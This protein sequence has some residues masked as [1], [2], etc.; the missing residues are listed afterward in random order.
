MP[1]LYW[2]DLR[3]LLTL[4]SR[5]ASSQ[6]KWSYL[7][8]LFFWSPL[9]W[10]FRLGPVFGRGSYVQHVCTFFFRFSW[11]KL[12][13]FVD[14]VLISLRSGKYGVWV[15]LYI[16]I[17]S[18]HSED[19]RSQWR[20]RHNLICGWK[21]EISPP[22]LVWKRYFWLYVLDYHWNCM[23][24]PVYTSDSPLSLFFVG[25]LFYDGSHIYVPPA[26]EQG[27]KATLPTLLCC[28]AN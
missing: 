5:C 23:L 15:A 26:E 4:L 22:L 10:E 6:H 3:L 9:P 8:Q 25:S 14:L 11:V 19:E 24:F 20:R 16:V 27:D 13:T 7:H 1:G 21:L 2:S 17:R 12:L 28:A 18:Y